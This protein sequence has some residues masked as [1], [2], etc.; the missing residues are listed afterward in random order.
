MDR[1]DFHGKHVLLTGATG[2]LGSALAMELARLG[3]DLVITSRSMKALQDLVSKLPD[4]IRVHP[5]LANLSIAGQADM[6]AQA[7]LDG[8]QHID[9]VFNNAAVGYFA[10]MEEAT[11]ENIRYL[12][13]LNT[14]SPLAL[15]KALLPHM[16]ARGS[17]RI[18]NIVS[19]AGRVPIPTVSVYGG[20]KSALATMANTMRVELEPAGI[21]IINV[22]PG[23]VDDSFEENALHEGDRSGLCPTDHCGEPKRSIA[24]QVIEAAQGQPGEV[25]LDRRGKWYSVAALLWPSYVDRRLKKLRDRVLVTASVK[26]R[27]WRLVQVESAVACNLKCVMCPWKAFRETACNHGIMP[28]EVW[29]RIRPHLP[30]IKSVDFTGGGEPLLQPNLL[31]WVTEAENAGCETGILTNGL[32]LNRELAPRLID[33]GLDWLC[34][35]IDAANKEDYEK[36]RIGSNF[37]KVCENLAAVGELRR[38][39]KPKTMINFVMMRSNFHQVEDMVH[40]AARLGVDQINFRQC[41]VIRGEHGKGFGLFATEETKE[42]RRM[43]AELAK[44][45]SLAKKLNIET[46]AFPFTPRERPVCEQDPRDE[47]FVRFDGNVAPCI[48]LAIGGPTTFLGKEILFPTEHYG[49]VQERDLLD[50]WENERCKFYRDRFWKRVR[51]YEQ[52]FMAGLTGDSRRTPERLHEEA[53]KR[54]PEAPEGCK[55]CHY[56]YDI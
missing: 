42:I 32:L 21:D 33:G 9:A 28:Q 49:L 55:T 12:F 29:E 39:G 34:V 25:W 8:M 13:E 56:L 45:R 37:D 53:V 43:Q 4:A 41:E 10:L 31:E 30:E 22:Y 15:V 40:L 20:S 18:V 36:I 17:G 51:V 7:A 38:D 47:V 26:P 6:L 3:A 5:V 1:Y 48:N 23:T 54:M 35:S 2:G 24:R 14:F 50:L 11:E 19:A 16:K 52:T 44:A 46:T 27:R